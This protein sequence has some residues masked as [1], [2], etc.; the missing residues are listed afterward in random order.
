MSATRLRVVVGPAATLGLVFDEVV[1]GPPDD[2]VVVSK[3]RQIDN[4]NEKTMRRDFI[5]LWLRFLGRIV[6][7]FFLIVF[8]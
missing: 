3:R 4:Q 8:G 5:F 2:I 7:F 1:V 6:F